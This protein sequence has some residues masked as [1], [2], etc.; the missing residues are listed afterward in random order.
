MPADLAFKLRYLR[1]VYVAYKGYHN[2]GARNATVDWT[3]QFPDAWDLV[4]KIMSRRKG[5]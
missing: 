3:Q 4:T 5:G 1:G 2:A